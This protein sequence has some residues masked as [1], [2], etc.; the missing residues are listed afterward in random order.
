MMIILKDLIKFNEIVVKKGYSKREF[1]R[2]CGVSEST[3]IQIA[4]GKQNPRPSTAK[5]IVQALEV[6]F[7]DV[8]VFKINWRSGLNV[9][10]IKNSIGA[11]SW[12]D[13]RIH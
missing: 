8:F 9:V 13:K 12:W 10:Y 3:F 11:R 6:N 4:N 2:K 1:A 5:K 7:D